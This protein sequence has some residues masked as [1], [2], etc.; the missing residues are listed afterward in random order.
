MKCAEICSFC[1]RNPL[2]HPPNLLYRPP[3]SSYPP[4][5]KGKLVITTPSQSSNNFQQV[6]EISRFHPLEGGPAG[7]YLPIR[8]DRSTLTSLVWHFPPLLVCPVSPDDQQS[9]AYA[10]PL[11]YDCAVLSWNNQPRERPCWY[12]QIL[13]R[14]DQTLRR[15]GFGWCSTRITQFLGACFLRVP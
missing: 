8:I 6:R 3:Y 11:R 14:R 12:A 9:M 15:L 7:R 13:A 1:C 5:I 10:S 2:P 4:S